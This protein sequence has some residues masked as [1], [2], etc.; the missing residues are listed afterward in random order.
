MTVTVGIIANPA[1]GR[2]LRRLTAQAGLHSS[3]DKANAIQRLLGAFAVTGVERVL[4]PT[5]MTGIAAAVLKASSGAQARAARWPQLEFLDFPLSQ[6][7]ADTRQ[8]ARL[9]V[10]RGVNLIAVLGGDGTHKAVAAEAGQVPL[11]A[12]ST[13]TNNAFPELRE[14][15]TAGLAGGLCASGRIPP[16]VGLRQNKRLLVTVPEQDLCECA[17]VDVAVSPRTFIGARALSRSEDLAQVFVT[18]GEPHAIGLSALAG[19]WCPV[20]RQAEHGA[21]LQLG[22]GSA[23]TLHAPLAPG[24]IQACGIR[25]WGPL[26]PGQPQPL[27]L[28]RGT[29]ALDGE[30]EIEF[31][32]HDHPQVTL[33][34]HGPLSIDV[35]AALAYAARER[36]LAMPLTFTR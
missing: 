23:H 30:R 7:V 15:T 10:A 21:W 36:L 19:L 4:L 20:S 14:T 11:L 24:V 29:L 2:D 33:D 35:E 27:V 12:L 1:S 6:T 28:P 8:A 31:S 9:M 5:D 17:L 18:F 26:P 3:T 34:R 16:S 22:E 25:A 32:D 13:G